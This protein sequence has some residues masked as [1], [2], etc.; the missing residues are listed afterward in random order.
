MG[1]L[2]Q[3]EEERYDRIGTKIIN[4]QAYCRGYLAR[5][6]AKKLKTQDIAIRCIQ[7]NV[8]KFMG[9][10]GWPWWRLLIKVTPMLNVHRTEN[11]L[12]SQTE[13]LDALRN[14][15]EK[16]DKERQEYKQ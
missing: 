9:V 4:L 15:Y 2:G 14:K 5:K 16:I 1:V 12:K 8:R 11:Q 3:L 7:K 13:E 6:K 10:R